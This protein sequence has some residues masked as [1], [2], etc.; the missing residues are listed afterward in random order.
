[1]A[2]GKMTLKLTLK[3]AA[4]YSGNADF[5]TETVVAVLN[6]R[7]EFEDF[8]QRL[9][10]ASLQLSRL[11]LAAVLEGAQRL[12]ARF[13]F[14]TDEDETQDLKQYDVEAVLIGGWPSRNTDSYSKPYWYNEDV[15]K[16]GIKL[17]IP[18]RLKINADGAAEALEF[19]I[20][21]T[22]GQTS[23]ILIAN[24]MAKPRIEPITGD[25]ADELAKALS[26]TDT[27]RDYQE[28]LQSAIYRKQET[29]AGIVETRERLKVAEG[30]LA[31]TMAA[32]GETASAPTAGA[33]E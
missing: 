5:S 9:Y 24:G 17:G 25:R 16:V 15:A 10:G 21:A 13:P 30:R 18:K 28:R 7:S 14:E 32:A 3:D 4:A 22:V 29:E 19:L 31:E 1:M 8:E 33:D 6:D 26:L 23:D 11:L 20:A 2:D 12:L 27:A